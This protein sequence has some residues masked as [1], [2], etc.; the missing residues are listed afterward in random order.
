MNKR[1]QA[2]M[3]RLGMTH[4]PGDDF[5]APWYETGILAA[6]SFSIG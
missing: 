3:R 2:V 6:D 1:S 5:D 4:D